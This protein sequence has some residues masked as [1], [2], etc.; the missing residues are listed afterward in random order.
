MR[1]RCVFN[2]LPEN[3]HRTLDIKQ[4]FKPWRDLL[5]KIVLN[6]QPAEKRS[7]KSLFGKEN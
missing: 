6:S 2:Y 4:N 7:A 5:P 3:I 1:R